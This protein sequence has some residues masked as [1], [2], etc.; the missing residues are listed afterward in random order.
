M[1]F[2]NAQMYIGVIVLAALCASAVATER[3]TVAEQL[4]AER[5]R[6]KAARLALAEVKVVVADVREAITLLG[7]REQ[8]KRPEH[9]PRA[10]D[11]ESP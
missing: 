7:E 5:E 9:S 10:V 8:E 3:R 4:L 6:R 11:S 2:V 1:L